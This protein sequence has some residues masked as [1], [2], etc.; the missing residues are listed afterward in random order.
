MGT[1]IDN[2]PL[3]IALC[4]VNDA[5]HNSCFARPPYASVGPEDRSPSAMMVSRVSPCRIVFVAR[6]PNTPLRRSRSNARRK[7]CETRSAL[8]WAF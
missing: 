7:K 8:P 2:Q 3:R 5:H 1:I 4:N 6:R